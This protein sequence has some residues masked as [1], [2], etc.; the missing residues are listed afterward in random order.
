M[1][2]IAVRVDD[3]RMQYRIGGPSTGPRLGPQALQNRP[4]GSA[5]D[6]QDRQ[7]RPAG[8]VQEHPG[9]PDHGGGGS[10]SV[11]RNTE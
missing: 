8:A 1:V 7:D 2:D 6:T 9:I 5:Q 10:R 11:V 3:L 4:F